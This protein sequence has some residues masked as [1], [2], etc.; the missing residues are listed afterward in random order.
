M[1]APQLNRRLIL[2]T[3]HRV[4]DG[5]GGFSQTWV[6]LGEHWAEVKARTGRERDE[7]GVPVSAV[8]YKITVRAAPDQSSARPMPR[9][10]FRDGS[11][12]FRIQAVAERDAQA[13]FLTCFSDEEVVA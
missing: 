4:P 13:R 7:A 9:Q 8:S 5:A 6:V 2:E 3:P 12:I 10:R 11:R 1:N